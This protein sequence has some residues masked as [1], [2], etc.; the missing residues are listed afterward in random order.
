MPANYNERLPVADAAFKK[1]ADEMKVWTEG[2]RDMISQMETIAP[3]DPPEA[4]KMLE[5][6]RDVFRKLAI[7]TAS[8]ATREQITIRAAQLAQGSENPQKAARF[9]RRRFNESADAFL[10]QLA[11]IDTRLTTLI[12]DTDP[13]ARGGP[14]FENADDLIAYLNS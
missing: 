14:S 13:E 5:S 4:T 8:Q 1:F 10:E 2:V 7:D 3:L 6:V 11:K 9:I 12:W